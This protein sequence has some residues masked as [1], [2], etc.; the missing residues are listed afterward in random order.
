MLPLAAVSLPVNVL[1]GPGQLLD[2]NALLDMGVK[3][4]SVGSSLYSA[5][6]GTFFRAAETLRQGSLDFRQGAM[7]HAELQ[8]RFSAPPAGA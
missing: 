6:M 1:G 5:A 8:T 3:R 7:S 2:A 4:V